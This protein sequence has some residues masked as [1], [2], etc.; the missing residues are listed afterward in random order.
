MPTLRGSAAR[1]VSPK[2]EPVTG[3]FTRRRLRTRRKVASSTSAASTATATAMTTAWLDERL[4][5]TSSGR[6][7]PATYSPGPDHGAVRLR[8]R[9][10]TAWSRPRSSVGHA[11]RKRC[12]AELGDLEHERARMRQCRRPAVPSGSYRHDDLVGVAVRPERGRRHARQVARRDG[13]DLHLDAVRAGLRVA[14]APLPEV[15]DELPVR[16]SRCRRPPS[17]R[18]RAG[19][20]W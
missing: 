9:G 20:V 3:S 6:S 13:T 16:E 17:R 14:I 10:G 15:Q 11:R 7:V 18:D 19:I 5:P 2:G 4:G 1:S 8:S 12:V